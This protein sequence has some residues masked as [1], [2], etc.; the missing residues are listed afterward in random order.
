MDAVT[1][2]EH[3]EGKHETIV[4]LHGWGMS[5]VFWQDFT[6]E[7]AQHY[8]VMCFDLPG[9]GHSPAYCDL[10]ADA[11]LEVILQKLDKPV[12]WMGWS[13]GGQIL[14]QLFK[15]APHLIRSMILVAASPCFLRRSDWPYGMDGQVLDAFAIE[16]QQDYHKTM[17]RFIGL[18]VMHSQSSVQ[19]LKQLRN[20]LNTSPSPQTLSLQQGLSL[21]KCADFRQDLEQCAVPLLVILGRQDQ[22][23]S[24]AVGEYYRGLSCK[25]TLV[26]MEGAGHA[27]FLSHMKQTAACVQQ[28]LAVGAC[29][30]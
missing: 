13:L 23:V 4:L 14:M 25:P 6:V 16:L 21:L 10:E 30:D 27:P 9:H 7:L 18:Q 22:L 11:V 29:G 5:S 8:H 19:S 26:V 28:F 3:G 20:M 15:R 12:H 2:I 24:A 1:C 17:S